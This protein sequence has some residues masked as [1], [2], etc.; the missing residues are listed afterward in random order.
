MVVG[1]THEDIGL[2][3]ALLLNSFNDQWMFAIKLGDP[4]RY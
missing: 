1:H 2:G 4:F 3:F